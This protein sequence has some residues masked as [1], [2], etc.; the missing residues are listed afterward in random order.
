MSYSFSSPAAEDMQ[1]QTLT[2]CTISSIA[3]L[4]KN[5]VA[6]KIVV[7]TGAGIS[8]AAGIPDFR[9]PN[10]GLYHNLARLELP[11]PEAVFEKSFF[12]DDPRPFYILAKELYPEN[13]K[14]TVSHAF[15]SLLAQRGL[16][17]MLFTQNIDCLERKAGVPPDLIV[18]AHGSFATQHCIECRA[19]FPDEEM[20]KYVEEGRPPICRRPDCGGYVK[21]DIVFFGEG[22]PSSFFDNLMVPLEADLVIVV[23]TSLTVYP[24]AELPRLAREGVPRLLFNMDPVGDFGQRGDDVLCLGSCDAGI[25]KLADE[26]GWREEL[27]KLWVGMVGEEEAE[28]QRAR[29]EREREEAVHQL[30]D[31][32]KDMEQKLE[33]SEDHDDRDAEVV[34][35]SEP[36][37]KKKDESSTAIPVTAAPEP[38]D[39]QTLATQKEFSPQN[40]ERVVEA[41]TAVEDPLIRPH[42]VLE[43]H[44]ETDKE[45][46]GTDS[47]TGLPSVQAEGAP[48]NKKSENALDNQSGSPKPASE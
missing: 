18:E 23:G 2:D 20:R 16:L 37:E 25:R 47:T 36:Q 11:H 10:T 26:L 44:S 13:F 14:P 8:T 29:N 15:V 19:S 30:D 40:S 1:P 43:Y 24:F 3:E 5:G 6:K 39:D 41:E 9:S 32:A 45:S 31:L 38:A 17:R 34:A 48:L 7:M 28:R 4:I 46:R 21:P 12:R 35:N 42:N 22:L 27:E 33:L